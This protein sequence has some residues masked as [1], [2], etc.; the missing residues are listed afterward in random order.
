MGLVK[1]P[2][3]W[4][5]TDGPWD[6]VYRGLEGLWLFN[7]GTGDMVADCSGHGRHGTVWGATWVAGPSGW[8]G[9]FDGTNDYVS[10]PCPVATWSAD[11]SV[12]IRYRQW[13][14]DNYDGILG[15]VSDTGNAASIRAISGSA[16]APTTVS[17]QHYDNTGP[18]STSFTT[19]ND[20]WVS[21]IGGVVGNKPHIYVWGV[22]ITSYL[23]GPQLLTRVAPHTECWFGCAVASA[24]GKLHAHCEVDYAAV[25][26][27]ALS[28]QE[29]R[30]LHEQPP[31][32]VG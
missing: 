5:I 26:S 8:L 21:V 9:S 3:G 30:R 11:Y 27:R 29:A 31:W 20:A 28:A 25:W 7:E 24:G 4:R 23:Q 32:M 12:L 2:R 18:R 10:C 13:S 15:V 14:Q 17:W 22:G 16:T 1:R 19:I 6:D